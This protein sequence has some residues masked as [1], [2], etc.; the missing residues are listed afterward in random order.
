M[1]TDNIISEMSKKEGIGWHIVEKDYFLTLLLE[2]IA[3]NPVLHDTLVFKGGTALRKIYFQ[4]YRYSEDL[5]FTLK[6][7]LAES[8]ARD[9]FNAVFEYLRKE[10]NANFT[11]KSFYHKNWFSDIK[12][13][14]FGLKGQ[15]NTITID[16][17]SDEIIV[18]K[19][20][21]GNVFN[22]YYG[23]TIPVSVYSLEEI[24]AEKLRS[25][26]QRTRVRDYYD[27]WYILTND[28]DKLDMR[29]VKEIFIKKVEYK[30]LAFSGKEQ[31]LEPDKI[32]QAKAYY[33][34][35]LKEH[36]KTLPDFDT[37]INELRE[38]IDEI[39]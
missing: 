20:Q 39:L 28:K 6:N 16:I 24:L 7:A 8:K 31:L 14:F 32:E 22:P 33:E 17:S 30:K 25:F 1:I 26:L 5:D 2:G 10:Y 27:A 38:S 11:I 12:I 19:V 9:S 18:D 34:R 37:L 3:A 15:K 23:K 29:K 36:L 21:K 13:Q 4:H 35:Q